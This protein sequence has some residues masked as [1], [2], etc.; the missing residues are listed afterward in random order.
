[1]KQIPSRRCLSWPTFV[2][3]GGLFGE[4]D[5]A[6]RYE[7]DGEPAAAVNVFSEEDFGGSGVAD[8]GEGG[9]GGG[10]EREVDDAEGEEQ[11]EEVERH[12]ECSREEDGAREHGSDGAEV[13]AE[14]WSGAVVVQVAEAAHGGGDEA[15]TR[16]GEGGDAENA[17]PLSKYGGADEGCCDRKRDHQRP[18]PESI[19]SSW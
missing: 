15:L 11:G 14:A 3:C 1:M 8:V 13:A 6:Y 10:G 9:C 5:D 16:D 17:D 18:A 7:E 4:K 12:A 2:K 19:R